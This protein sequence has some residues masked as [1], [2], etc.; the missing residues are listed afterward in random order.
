[1]SN[2]IPTDPVGHYAD[3]PLQ[4]VQS[5]YQVTVLLDVG[6]HEVVYETIGAD[7][8]LRIVTDIVRRHVRD[9]G[10]CISSEIVAT[11]VTSSEELRSWPEFSAFEQ[12]L[13][14]RLSREL[15]DLLATGTLSAT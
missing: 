9:D 3:I 8:P 4:V 1:M 13:K 14:D 7:A 2:A 15:Q 11:I 6:G 10:T 5:Q 12:R